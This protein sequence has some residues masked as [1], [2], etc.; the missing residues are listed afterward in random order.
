M[1]QG[2]LFAVLGLDESAGERQFKEAYRR[3]AKKFH[4]DV[5][6]SDPD[7]AERF[8]EIAHAYWIL[9]DPRRR[10]AY[11]AANPH[12]SVGQA[13]KRRKSDAPQTESRDP[14]AK[15]PHSRNGKDIVIKLYLTLEELAEGVMKKVKLRRRISCSDC[16]G[17]GIAGG[18][19]GGLCP[20]CKG[21]GKVPDFIN[22]SDALIS[23][24]KC[25][26]TGIQP[27]KACSSCEGLGQNLNDVMITVGIPPGSSD[28]DR[29]IVKSQGHEGHPGG[30]AGDLQVIIKQKE[31][32]Y[33]TRQGDDLIY[34]CTISLTQWLE[35]CEL[36]VPSL[37]NPIALKIE[38]GKKSSGTLKVRGRGMPKNG[39]GCGDLV[40]KYAL[41]RPQKIS[42][43][44]RS[45]LKRLE[46]TDGFSPRLDARGWCTRELEEEACD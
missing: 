2:N 40:V 19:K 43:K 39:G 10:K 46:A 30:E 32:P 24:R 25:G 22:G 13:G 11:L 45:I 29:V 5:N 34:H 44:Q 17:T 6:H 41:S 36:R 15:E 12:F 1:P 35:G 14:S 16:E 23:C 4:P 27:M 33:F 37:K 38:S 20:S 28:Q 31:H 18:A 3:L 21:T 7:A 42:K 26:G 9:S 8:K